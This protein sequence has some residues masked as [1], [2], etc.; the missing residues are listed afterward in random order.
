MHQ[1]IWDFSKTTANIAAQKESLE[2]AKLSLLSAKALLSYKVKLLYELMSVQK[3]AMQVRKKDL[4]A[5]SALYKQAQALVEQGMKTTV[6]ASR[7]LSAVYSAQDTLAIAKANFD[8]A[9]NSLSIYIGEAIEPDVLLDA[10]QKSRKRADKEAILN[11]SPLLLSLKK[12]I[13]K[14]ELT[15]KSLQASQYGSIDAIASYA[16]IGSLNEYDSSYAGVTLSIPLYSGG[17]ISASL[18][19]AKLEQQ[20]AQ[21]IYNS[22]M[23]ELKEEVDS[24]LIDIERY[25]KSIKAKKAQLDTA[26]QTYNLLNARYSEGLATYIE[27]LDA[28][29]LK[30]SAELGLINTQY[31]RSSALHKLEYLQGKI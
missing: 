21:A 23:L 27:V 28:S 13:K 9:R 22:K 6:D 15:Y 14:S 12:S 20:S 16:R 25:T 17:K 29:S 3:T 26:S 31:E 10:T 7:F 19:Q 24:T 5:K 11:N 4:E 2:A 30:L 18:E 1:K 8:K